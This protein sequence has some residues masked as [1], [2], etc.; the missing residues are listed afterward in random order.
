[1]AKAERPKSRGYDD[2][3]MILFGDLEG[4]DAAI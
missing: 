1:M 4:S 2:Y 3:Q